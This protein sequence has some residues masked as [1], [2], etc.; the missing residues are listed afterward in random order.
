M[1]FKHTALFFIALILPTGWVTAGDVRTL[2]GEYVVADGEGTEQLEAVF[3]PAGDGSWSVVFHFKFQDQPHTFTGSADGS[4]V[5]GSL[6][7]RVE[8]PSGSRVFTFWG[9]LGEEATPEGGQRKIF[10][11]SHAEI[12]D[13]FE[14]PTGTLMLTE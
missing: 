8:N 3:T 2:T 1:R 11:G 5:Q 7:G 13:G 12:E 6:E 14:N 4:L 9:E 10:R